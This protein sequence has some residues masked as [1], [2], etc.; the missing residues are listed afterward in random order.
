MK[1]NYLTQVSIIWSFQLPL[2]FMHHEYY[3]KILTFSELCHNKISLNTSFPRI[4][5]SGTLTPVTH[6]LLYDVF[7]LTWGH[8]D[9]MF[10]YTEL[11]SVSLLLFSWKIEF[12]GVDSVFV[13]VTDKYYKTH[14]N[15][16]Y[17]FCGTK[18]T[19]TYY[20]QLTSS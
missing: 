18:E 2:L 7:Y 4:W 12:L 16:T 8:T 14:F 19:R 17:L 15:S 20:P 10:S 5:S 1:N 13:V 9:K 11:N 3:I 6:L